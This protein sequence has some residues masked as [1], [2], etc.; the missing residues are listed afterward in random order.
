MAMIPLRQKITLK[1][2]AGF[3]EWGAPLFEQPIE[4]RARVDEGSYVTSD[5]GAK[6]TG[7]VELASVRIF[8][9]KL[10]QVG[11][12]DLISFTNELGITIEQTPKKVT[13]KRNIAGKVEMTE[14]YL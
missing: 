3:D 10:V 12:D 4:I 14:V 5:T 13:V 1:R 8:L 11:Y 9:D 7:G 6:Q 2:R